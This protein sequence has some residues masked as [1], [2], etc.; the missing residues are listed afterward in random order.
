MIFF[1]TRIHFIVYLSGLLQRILNHSL[2][3]FNQD[4][5]NPGVVLC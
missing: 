3:I 1:I 2:V 5:L 4:I